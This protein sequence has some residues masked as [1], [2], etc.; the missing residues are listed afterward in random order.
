MARRSG[1]KG[2]WLAT[3]DYTGFTTY[4]SKLRRD[5]W[6]SYAQ[7]PLLRNLQEIATPL[8]DPQPVSL[9]R[10][11]NYEATPTCVAEV[12]PTFIGLT[13]VATNPNN[14]AFQAL[15]LNPAIPDMEI[16]CTFVVR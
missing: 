3:D 10:G 2:D 11:P 6:G 15:D 5:Y 9:Y 7:K 8:N 13:H 1:R 12:A 4:A 14:A 16:G